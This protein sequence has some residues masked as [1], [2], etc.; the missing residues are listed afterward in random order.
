M[1]RRHRVALEIADPENPNRYLA[2]RG[3]VVEITE[4]GADEHLDRLARRYLGRDRYPD[5]YRFPGEV[6]RLYRIAPERVSTW[7]PF[8]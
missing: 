4:A 8:G 6:R 5:S 7:D 3:R 1:E 2:V